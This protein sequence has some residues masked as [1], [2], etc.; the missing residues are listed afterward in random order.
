MARQRKKRPQGISKTKWREFERMVARI[1]AFL[2]REDIKVTSPDHLVDVVTGASREVDASLRYRIGS[3]Y[4]II[5][6]ECRDRNGVE[7]V[8]WIEQLVTKQRDIKADKCI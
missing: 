8:Q 3:S 5:T 2:C 7:D 6:I 1:E 4:G